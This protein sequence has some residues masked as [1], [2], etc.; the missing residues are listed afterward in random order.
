VEVDAL[1]EELIE[2]GV[3]V[4][5]GDSGSLSDLAVSTARRKLL[6]RL[7]LVGM[8]GFVLHRAARSVAREG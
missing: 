1:A 3:Q 7:D 2:V 6:R 5:H 8:A 4:G